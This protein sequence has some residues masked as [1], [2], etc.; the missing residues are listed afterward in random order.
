M[1]LT[2]VSHYGPK[3]PEFA[4]LVRELQQILL[5]AL[6]ERFSPY[7]IE[8]IHGTII[9][10][11]GTPGERGVLSDNFRQL[12]NEERCF[13]FA[14]ML[15][16]FRREFSGFDVQVGGFRA[17]ENYSF[18]SQQR[19]PFLRSFSVQSATAVAM[20]WPRDEA[21]FPPSLDRLR[22]SLERFGALR[23][24][25][26]REGEVDNDF[27]FVLGQ[28]AGPLAEAERRS[29]ES[30]AREWLSANSQTL[31]VGHETLSFVAYSDLRVP[32]ETSRAFRLNDSATTAESLAGVYFCSR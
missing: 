2:L 12:R 8:Q 7:A 23:K 27:Y 5:E 26:W 3:P 19:S 4:V 14:G 22:R 31:H 17:N 21:T 30:R 18:L 24:W 11:E 28:I 16:F 1:Q 20:G 6:G 25:A 10:L 15:Q 32:L 9:G 29:I 13:D